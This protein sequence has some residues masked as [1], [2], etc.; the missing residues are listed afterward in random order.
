MKKLIFFL[1]LFISTSAS[2]QT[3]VSDSS[4]LQDIFIRQNLIGEWKD[5]NSTTIFKKNGTYSTTFD[6]GK[7]EYGKWS[8]EK[9]ILSFRGEAPDSFSAYF[10]AY[11]ILFFSPA[12]FEYQLLD[13]QTDN[14]IWIA[15][16]IIKEKK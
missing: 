1:I 4:I 5:Q 16:K 8:V 2:G 9:K 15:F 6:D 7:A 14:T 3:S 10:T 13:A 11:K 12:K